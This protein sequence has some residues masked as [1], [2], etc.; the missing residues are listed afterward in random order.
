MS[1][2]KKTKIM[3][4]EYGLLM[5]NVKKNW[6]NIKKQQTNATNGHQHTPK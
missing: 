6:L 2:F 5:N 3:K 4:V 1:D